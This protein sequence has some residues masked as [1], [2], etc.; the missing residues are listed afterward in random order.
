VLLAGGPLRARP[1]RLP[2]APGA[3]WWLVLLVT[4]DRERAGRRASLGLAAVAV[5]VALAAPD[6]FDGLAGVLPDRPLGRLAR[7]RAQRVVGVGDLVAGAVVLD[8]GA[9]LSPG[10]PPP[11][12]VRHRAELL[13]QVGG[14]LVL[15]GQAAGP[16][17]PG[18]LP[19]HLP[20]GGAEVRIGLQP[21][22][23]ALLMPPQHQLGVVGPVGLLAGHQGGGPVGRGRPGP[24]GQAK[25]PPP[26]ALWIAAGSE[27]RQGLVGLG[28]AGTRPH[29]LPSPIP[30]G[31]VEQLAEPVAFGP[32]LSGG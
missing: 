14:R 2:I 24:P 8:G 32:Q 25:H 18:Q 5:R 9:G 6:P 29:K 22:G 28:P 26:L 20:V 31:L 27:P 17:L 23:P 16:A 12:A 3:G 11:G 1:A 15:G 10:P 13:A 4:V 7:R 30:R 21:A 19:D